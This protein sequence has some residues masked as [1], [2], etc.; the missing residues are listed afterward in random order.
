VTTAQTPPLPAQPESPNRHDA[1][2]DA[3]H[4]DL[5]AVK[6]IK[7]WGIASAAALGVSVLMPW[8]T[9][10]GTGVALIDGGDGPV[11]LV[12]AAVVVALTV[13][14]PQS[15]GARVLAVVAGGLGLYEFIHVY[16][17]INDGRAE[18][19]AFGALVSVAFGAYLACLAALSL[20]AW[21][22]VTQFKKAV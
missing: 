16:V 10:L 6:A 4:G 19:G 22:A 8:V 1:K 9:V 18:A 2:A 12:A 15:I 21:A 5:G 3:T 7:V 14:R 20:V 13:W 17:T 11:L